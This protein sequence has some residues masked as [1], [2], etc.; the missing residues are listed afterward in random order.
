M[1]C[2]EC[3]NCHK[4]AYSSD[5]HNPWKCPNCEANIPTANKTLNEELMERYQWNDK[6][7]NQ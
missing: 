1:E 4:R 5:S 6:E 3:P 2:R 7:D